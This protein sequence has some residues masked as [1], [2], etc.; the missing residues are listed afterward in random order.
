MA[1]FSQKEKSDGGNTEEIKKSHR[2]HAIS[3]KVW[4]RRSLVIICL[5]VLG[6]VGLFCLP[7]T[8]QR[9][10]VD[11]KALLMGVTKPSIQRKSDFLVKNYVDMEKRMGS[12]AGL[13]LIDRVRAAWTLLETAQGF[14]VE[15]PMEWKTGT[16]ETKEK[17][18]VSLVCDSVHSIVHASRSDGTESLLLGVGVDFVT[19]VDTSSASMLIWNV[20]A[21]HL[22]EQGWLAKNVVLVLL[23]VSKCTSEQALFSWVN[24]NLDSLIRTDRR[25]GQIQQAILVDMESLDMTDATIKVHGL[26]GQLPNYDMYMIARRNLELYSSWKIKVEGSPIGSRPGNKQSEEPGYPRN[27]LTTLARFMW[28]QAFGIPSG[29][30][31]IML[32][33]GI[34]SLSISITSSRGNQFKTHGVPV[35]QFDRCL[36]L[37]EMMVR[38]MN[39]LQEKLHHSTAFYALS[40]PFSTIEVSMFMAPPGILLVALVLQTADLL[41][42]LQKHVHHVNWKHATGAAVCLHTI[43]ISAFTC[44]SISMESF[45]LTGRTIFDWETVRS[46]FMSVCGI[47]I[48]AFILWKY[49]LSWALI[50]IGEKEDQS[51]KTNHRYNL[52]AVKAISAVLLCCT[53]PSVLL[54]RWPLAWML[55]VCLIP[56]SLH[57]EKSF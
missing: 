9:G 56:L 12:S 57:R 10:N 37:L 55:L 25:I 6:V 20:L 46:C 51:L 16:L 23:D 7:M 48:F 53:L 1:R 33:R 17:G 13:G 22:G 24:S 19:R 34:D 3:K 43:F 21:W 40:G 42:K 11:E 50:A 4:E 36:Q 15:R 39:N 45:H 2:L 41:T 27:Q 44:F 49:T 29:P 26:G 32:K 8:A 28:H 18:D 31:S 54:W 5:Y 52:V 35:V 30:H 38:T 47:L 14:T